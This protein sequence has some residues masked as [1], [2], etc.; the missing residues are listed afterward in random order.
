MSV[1]RKPRQHGFTLV[2][3]MV[4]VVIVGIMAGVAL[5]AINPDDKAKTA[6][7]FND[8]VSSKLDLTRQRA[9]STQKLQRIVIEANKIEFVQ[10]PE[11]GMLATYELDKVK[12]DNSWETVEVLTAPEGVDI[13][14]VEGKALLTAGSYATSEGDN[15]GVSA[16]VYIRPDGTVGSEISSF[17]GLTVY[18][19]NT[20]RTEK[21]RTVQFRITGSV[22]V[23]E[24]W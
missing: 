2:E 13:V 10:A 24:N 6:R 16:A 17:E 23:F 20:A 3:L 1:I 14:M 8:M 15:L 7:G 5:I 18:V 12:F 21:H 19:G 4:V 22:Q 9:V 11:V